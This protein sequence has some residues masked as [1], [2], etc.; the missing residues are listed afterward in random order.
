MTHLVAGLGNPGLRYELSRH[1]AG[2][3]VVDHLGDELRASYWRDAG[4]AR[5]A[6]VLLGEEAVV[7]AKPQTFMNVSGRSVATLVEAYEVPMERL[8]VVH[9]DID[10]LEGT[11]RVKQ[12][13]GHGG[14]KG[15]RSLHERLES[16]D[17]L[18][19]RIGVGRPPGRQDPA[20]YVL[21]PMSAAAAD[22]MGQAVLL[23]TRA[24]LHIIEHGVDSAMNEFNSQEPLLPGDGPA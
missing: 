6:E 11:I 19:V 22:A 9:D 2:F 18:R 20:D 1:N 4:G 16:G 5:I 24:V 14:H 13:G 23:G 10:L 7:L 15:L 21:E 8:I 3:M 17:Y 12:G